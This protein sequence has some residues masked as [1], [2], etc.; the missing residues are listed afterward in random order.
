MKASQFNAFLKSFMCILCMVVQSVAWDQHIDDD[1][2]IA[3]YTKSQCSG[4]RI[5]T[6]KCHSDL[7][8]AKHR[9]ALN[10]CE[11]F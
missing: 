5:L 3:M 9:N 7:Y 11:W 2:L 4:F 8:I 1:S 6:F 10:V